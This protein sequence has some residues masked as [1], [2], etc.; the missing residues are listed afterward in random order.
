MATNSCTETR[1]TLFCVVMGLTEKYQKF[2]KKGKLNI[3]KAGKNPQ[4]YITYQYKL[5][6]KCI[7]KPIYHDQK[8]G[9]GSLGDCV[10][11]MKRQFS[12]RKSI[13]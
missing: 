5:I 7:R 8:V 1:S 12:T 2:Y 4:I 10:S 13:N 9:G 11:G 3:D 6:S